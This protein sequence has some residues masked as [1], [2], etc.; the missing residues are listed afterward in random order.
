MNELLNASVNA[1]RLR[2]FFVMQQTF[3]LTMAVTIAAELRP[4]ATGR[5]ATVDGRPG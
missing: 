5:I 3:T 4:S 1:N 2:D